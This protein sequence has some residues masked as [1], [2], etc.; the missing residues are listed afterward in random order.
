LIQTSIPS[1]FKGLKVKPIMT[2]LHNELEK[3]W[4]LTDA[5]ASV[6]EQITFSG[7]DPILSSIFK[8]GT[9][10]SVS[11]AAQS[12][13]AAQIWRLRGGQRQNVAVAMRAAAAAFRSERY[14]GIG[15]QPARSL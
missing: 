5:D 14:Q 10:A 12:L 7:A 15:K 6:L 1:I 3:I 2:D 8:V 9:A 13:M 4:L 11:I